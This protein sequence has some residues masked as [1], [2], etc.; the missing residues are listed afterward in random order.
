[1]DITTSADVAIVG[2][3]IV[4]CAA[5]AILAESG[6]SVVLVE[7]TAIAAGASG[8]NS[9]VVQHPVDPVLAALHV[10]TVELYRRLAA[11]DDG[12]FA[13]AA[14][15]AG[16]LYVSHR[17]AV[18]A[19]LAAELAASHPHLSPEYLD[20]ADARR[21][22][23]GL[24]AGVAACRLDIGF[25]IAPAAAT[26]AYARAAER[27]GAR[28]LLA[29]DAQL[30]LAGGRCAGVVVDGRRIDAGSVIVA[31]GP[32]TPGI[33]DPVGAWRPIR[34]NWGVVAEM[35]L[36]R[37]P[38]HVLEEALIDATI[39]PDGTPADDAGLAFS[40]VT[41][42]GRS[43]L[44]STFLDA[45]PDPRALAPRLRDRGAAFLPAIADAAMVATRSCARPLSADGRPLVGQVG[46]VDGLFVAAGHGPWGIST[47]P[48]TARMV[49]DAVVGRDGRIPLTLDPDRFGRP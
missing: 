19:A 11:S 35:A 7:R 42:A 30:D 45:E 39:E 28:L 46:W 41:A 34:P 32:W 48:A 44:G 22:E 21:L 33:V 4:G 2:G 3:G 31:A 43:V 37:P 23:P 38:K 29:A 6:A 17:A 47:G 26:Q 14:R 36:D 13:L 24:A 18:A 8:R 12:G 9:G 5:A 16:L 40:L 25:P 10:E 15:P 49:V 20:P 27:A 1:M